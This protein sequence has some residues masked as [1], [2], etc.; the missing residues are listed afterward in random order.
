[1][2]S[3]RLLALAGL[4]NAAHIPRAHHTRTHSRRNVTAELAGLLDTVTAGE[5][6]SFDYVV[7]GGGT[8]GL[9][10]LNFRSRI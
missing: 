8:A 7:I 3:F 9:V 1:M 10:R 4:L 6:L 5:N 2:I